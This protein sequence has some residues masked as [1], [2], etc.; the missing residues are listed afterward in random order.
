MVKNIAFSFPARI[1]IET[2]DILRRY[3]LS[4]LAGVLL[5]KDFMEAAETLKKISGMVLSVNSI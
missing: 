5:R 4:G 2:V 3:G 1:V